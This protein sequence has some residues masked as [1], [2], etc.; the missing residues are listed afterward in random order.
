MTHQE[1]E[2]LLEYRRNFYNNPVNNERLKEESRSA[3]RT[4]IERDVPCSPNYGIN[5][6]CAAIQLSI[7]SWGPS[8]CK[9]T[10]NEKITQSIDAIGA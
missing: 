9:K 6:D 5:F 2:N 10:K 7:T 1:K 3:Y 4:K 8:C